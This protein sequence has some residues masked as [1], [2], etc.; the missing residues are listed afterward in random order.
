[1]ATGFDA[2]VIEVIFEPDPMIADTNVD[3]REVAGVAGSGAAAAQFS[4]SPCAKPP[5]PRP[6]LNFRFRRPGS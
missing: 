1:M 3:L 4:A 6:S 5:K 2:F